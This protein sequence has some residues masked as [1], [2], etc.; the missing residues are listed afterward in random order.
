MKVDG[1][2]PPDR[3][4]AGG[5]ALATAEMTVINGEANSRFPELCRDKCMRPKLPQR[6]DSRG[7][8]QVLD[9]FVVGLRIYLHFY[10][11]SEEQ[12]VLLVP[13]FIGEARQWWLY[14]CNGQ[15]RPK[16]GGDVAS[17]VQGLLG[18]F[19]PRSAR[20]QGLGELRKLKQGKLSIDRYIE[21]YQ[22]LVQKSHK[23][24]PEL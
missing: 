9:E 23:V 8:A 22:S 18:R 19:I 5:A 10:I 7:E 14:F 21:E 13:C 12:R 4:T 24:D 16:W 6:R 3:Q 15:E 17:F 20:K 1:H 11:E 2:P